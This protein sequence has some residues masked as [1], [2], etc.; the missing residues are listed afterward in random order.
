MND[1]PD[2]RSQVATVLSDVQEKQVKAIFND[3]LL[4]WFG[5]GGPAMVAAA[6]IVSF[7]TVQFAQPEAVEELESA[8]IDANAAATLANDAA[9]VIQNR[10]RT[11]DNKIKNVDAILSHS[12][13]GWPYAIRCSG[14]PGQEI[15]HLYRLVQ[16]PTQNNQSVH[17]RLN[18]PTLYHDVVLS[19]GG[20]SISGYFNKV[21]GI[22]HDCDI[23][24]GLEELI[25]R[26]DAL[27]LV[28]RP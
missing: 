15:S 16:I 6:A 12:L 26:G 25:V 9:S 21:D 7:V 3:A 22:E 2:E 17:Y 4:K 10:F 1:S 13:S 18:A 14:A 27:Y 11:Q 20:K 19:F 23:G 28:R 24:T 5:I 8:T